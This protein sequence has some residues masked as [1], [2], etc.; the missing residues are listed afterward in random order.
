M[1]NHRRDDSPSNRI[2]RRAF[3]VGGLLTAG[4]T[5][6]VDP[7]PST[8]ATD[9]A[10][11][12]KLPD[13]VTVEAP[14]ARGI[15]ACQDRHPE[16]PLRALTG[17][18][19][20]TPRLLR[21]YSFTT[22]AQ[23]AGLRAGD[24]L[25]SKST[26]DS[27]HRG[28][29]FDVLVR[30]T[31]STDATP[32]TAAIAKELSGPRFEKGRF[33]WPFLAGT[34]LSPERYGDEILAFDFR[35]EALFVVFHGHLYPHFDFYDAAG[36]RVDADV[37]MAAPER[38]GAFLF[39]SAELSAGTIGLSSCRVPGPALTY[40]EMY[41]GNLAMISQWRLGTQDILDRIA[42]E[43][44]DLRMLVRDHDC[45]HGRIGASCTEVL[46]LWDRLGP[47]RMDLFVGSTA[48]A[49]PYGRYGLTL[50]DLSR[51]ADDLESL[52]FAPNPLVVN[53]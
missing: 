34:R 11:R 24:P 37:A 50:A 9:E 16:T 21:A 36:K 8:F 17:L 40:R 6:R 51:L 18:A 13:P 45:S 38:I 26:T 19:Q 46:T 48:F 25:L 35:P 49:N 1:T 29:L 10:P 42:A 5:E 20:G 33:A 39:S 52:R 44:D 41:L 14:A 4:C 22:A 32:K 30:H 2:G 27:G 23:A 12:P 28:V 53:P 47:R 31:T 7:A 15:E 43:V 3:V